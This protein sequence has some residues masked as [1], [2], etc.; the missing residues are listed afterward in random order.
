LA[1]DPIAAILADF[2][3]PTAAAQALVSAALEAGGRDNVTVAIADVKAMAEP[4]ESAR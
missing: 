2:D 4:T 3:D 1:D